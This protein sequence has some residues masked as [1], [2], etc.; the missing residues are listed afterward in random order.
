MEDLKFLFFSCASSVFTFGIAPFL[1]LG[2]LF[3]ARI[4]RPQI[5]K[6]VLFFL[7][8]GHC[9]LWIISAFAKDSQAVICILG[10]IY[11]LGLLGAPVLWLV[12]LL[13]SIGELTWIIRRKVKSEKAQ[14]LKEDFTIRAFLQLIILAAIPFGWLNFILRLAC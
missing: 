3:V 9:I 1:W 7:M 4:K 14:K 13:W 10:P 2:L 5:I 6:S 8:Y 12:L 11:F